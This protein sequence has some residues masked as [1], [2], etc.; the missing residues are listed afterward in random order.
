MLRSR[1]ASFLSQLF[2][3]NIVQ[4]L[5]SADMQH[6]FS[7]H[8]RKSKFDRIKDWIKLSRIKIRVLVKHTAF[9][10]TVL[11]MVFLNTMIVATNHYKQP[12]WL[13]KFQGKK[14][15]S[16]PM[17]RAATLQVDWLKTFECDV[18][19]GHT[20]HCVTTQLR[21]RNTD[22]CC[23]YVDQ[24]FREATRSFVCNGFMLGQ[25]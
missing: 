12:K 17:V 1:E 18:M 4:T 22:Q 14:T 8:F 10:W 13:D 20:R 16:C 2:C 5:L 21:G 6:L 9:Y 23:E 24:R 7:L 3:L 25:R 15:H 11:V 19:T